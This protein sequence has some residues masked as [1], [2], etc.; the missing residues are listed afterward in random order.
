MAVIADDDGTGRE[1]AQVRNVT[2]DHDVRAQFGAVP[3]RGDT[4]AGLEILLITSRETRR[5]IIPK[6]WPE[7]GLDPVAVA[8]LEAEQEAGVRGRIAAE[9]VGAFLYRKL[10]ADGRAV[11]CEVTVFPLEVEEELAAWREA[12]ERERR[13]FLPAEAARRVAE[14]ALAALLLRFEDR[15]RRG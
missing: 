11:D 15:I 13:W 5:W 2:D 7:P 8:A 12:K 1:G 9:P 6:G 3:Y 14:P 10:L 4:A